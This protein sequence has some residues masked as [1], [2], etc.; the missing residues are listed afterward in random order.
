MESKSLFWSYWGWAMAIIG[1]LFIVPRIEVLKPAAVLLHNILLVMFL[2]GWRMF[3]RQNK[4][5]LLLA[6]LFRGART[7]LL[8]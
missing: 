4:K 8:C 5:A 2:Y 1:L 7:L 3:Y 6:G